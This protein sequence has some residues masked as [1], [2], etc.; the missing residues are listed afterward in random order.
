[1]PSLEAPTQVHGMVFA[2]AGDNCVAML[3]IYLSKIWLSEMR[4]MLK[5]LALQ[6]RIVRH[7]TM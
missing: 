7:L 2:G 3:I 5:K 4:K 1:V 6:R